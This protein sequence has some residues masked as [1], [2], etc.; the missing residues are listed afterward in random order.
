MKSDIER[1]TTPQAAQML[2]ISRRTLF[3]WMDAGKARPTWTAPGKN[4][5]HVWSRHTLEQIAAKN[6]LGEL[7][8]LETES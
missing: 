8:E 2:G 5:Q 6:G 4:G 7:N 3:Y 1:F